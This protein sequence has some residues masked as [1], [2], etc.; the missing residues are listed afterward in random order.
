LNCR[1]GEADRRII[2]GDDRDTPGAAIAYAAGATRISGGEPTGFR[3]NV[4]GTPSISS[5]QAWAAPEV[6]TGANHRREVAQPIKFVGAPPELLRSHDK[7]VAAA[8]AVDP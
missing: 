7:L 2:R 3:W 5:N 1:N 4:P 6:S 8:L